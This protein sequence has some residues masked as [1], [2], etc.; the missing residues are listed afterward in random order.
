M[1]THQQCFRKVTFLKI[2]SVSQHSRK[3]NVDKL[4]SKMEEVII[5]VP[6][7]HFYIKLSFSKKKKLK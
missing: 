2:T 3:F 7:I 6:Q 5:L 4:Q 1:F